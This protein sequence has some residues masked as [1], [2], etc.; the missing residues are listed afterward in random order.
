[1]D[2]I[3]LYEVMVI[4]IIGLACLIEFWPVSSLIHMSSFSLNAMFVQA[5]IYLL[6]TY[7]VS[8]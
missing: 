7:C 3:H 6:P 5:T 1:M 4:F 2:L 8:F